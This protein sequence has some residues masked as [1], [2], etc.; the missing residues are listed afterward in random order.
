VD[1]QATLTSTGPATVKYYWVINGKREHETLE[2]QVNGSL[3]VTWG[4]GGTHGAS[5]TTGSVELV[6]VSPN[7]ASSGST[8]FTATCPPKADASA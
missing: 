8:A 1:F 6:V 3:N 5:E 4:I 7:A 2:R